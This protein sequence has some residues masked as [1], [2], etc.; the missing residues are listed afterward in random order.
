MVEWV[1]LDSFGEVVGRF[2]GT[3]EELAAHLLATVPD[4]RIG[5][6]QDA[7]VYVHSLVASITTPMVPARTPWC[8]QRWIPRP[9]VPAPRPHSWLFRR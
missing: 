7:E 3:A 2:D 6:Q 9:A 5:P 1:Q 8:S 4:V